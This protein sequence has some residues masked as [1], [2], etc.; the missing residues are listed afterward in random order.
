MHPI[1]VH[2]PR[3]LLPATLE[4]A[5]RHEIYPFE[6]SKQMPYVTTVERAG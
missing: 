1:R 2:G 5:F 3:D 4:A 6:E